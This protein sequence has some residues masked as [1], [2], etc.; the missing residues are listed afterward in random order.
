MAG[1]SIGLYKYMRI[2]E[3]LQKQEQLLESSSIISREDNSSKEETDANKMFLC[4][5]EFDRMGLE[6]VERF[7]KFRDIPKD[8]R[9]WMG[10]RQM[11]LVYSICY[12]EAENDVF[13]QNGNFF[14]NIESGAVQSDRLFIGLTILQ[15]G[16]SVKKDCQNV[17]EFFQICRENI[18]KLVKNSGRDLK[19]TVMGTLGSFG[20]TILWLANQYQDVLHLVT[21]I[22]NRNIGSINCEEKS[23]F[24]SA[25]T[26]FARNHKYGNNWDE[27]IRQIQ[28]SAI[29]SITL[30]VGLSDKICKNFINLLERL[31]NDK[32]MHCTGEH[33]VI[34]RIKSSNAFTLFSKNN[35]LHYRSE[36]YRNNLLQTNVNLCEDKEIKNNDSANNQGG[37]EKNHSDIKNRNQKGESILQI[38]MKALPELNSVADNYKELRREFKESFQSTTGMIDTLDMLFSDYLS[39]IS[40]ATN[41]MWADTLSHQFLCVL[42]CIKEICSS[43]DENSL[44]NSKRMGSINELLSDFARQVSYI[45]ESN[46]LVLATPVCQFQYL[47]QNNLTL[48]AYLGIMK[49]VLGFVYDSQEVSRQ[50]EIVPLMVAEIVPIIE[51]SMHIG[52]KLTE[53]GSKVITV[54]MPMASLYDAICYYPYLYHEIFH[55]VVPKD[56]YVRNRLTGSMISMEILFNITLVIICEGLQ[57]NHHTEKARLLYRVILEC[58]MPFIYKF[59]LRNYDKYINDS[60]ID[61][62]PDNLEYS[63]IDSQE[64]STISREYEREL[65]KRWIESLQDSEYPELKNNFVYMYFQYLYEN[66]SAFQ[67]CI[68]KWYEKNKNEKQADNIKS[69]VVRFIENLDGMIR[70][71]EPK[72]AGEKFQELIGML[73]DSV[74]NDAYLFAEALREL[75][76]DLAMVSLCHLEY[77]EYLLLFTKI[78]RDLIIG[79]KQEIQDILRVGIIAEYYYAASLDEE[80]LNDRID[81]QKD[82]YIQMYCGLFYSNTKHKN[83]IDY[84]YELADE[85]EKWFE[86]W[87]QCCKS[88]MLRYSIYAALFRS[89]CG[90][91]LVTKESILINGMKEE[92]HSYWKKYAEYLLEFGYYLL[93]KSKHQTE[94]QQKERRA[95]MDKQIFNLNIKLIHDFQIQ[96]E[97]QELN[98]RREDKRKKDAAKV[99]HNN[100]KLDS[101]N[102]NFKK[103]QARLKDIGVR[104]E[105]YADRAGQAADIITVIADQLNLANDRILGR[106]EHP[107]WYRG[108]EMVEYK[109]I[110]NIM[111]KYKDKKMEKKNHDEFFI[112]AYLR[113]EY[114]EFKFRTDGSVEAID[115]GAY[116]DADYIALMQ[117]YS[118]PTNFLDWT[119]DAMSALYFALEGF[120]DEKVPVKKGD[121][122]LYLFSPELY[123][124]ARNKMLLQNRKKRDNKTEIEKMILENTCTEVIPNISVSYHKDSYFMFLLGN[125]KYQTGGNYTEAKGKWKYYMPMAVY[126]S[127]L[128]NRI[129]AQSGN[130]LAYNIYTGPDNKNEF[131]H[132]DL[133]YIQKEYLKEY[134]KNEDT[135]PFLYKVIIKEAYRKEIAKWVKTFGMAKEKCYPELANIGERIMR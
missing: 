83:G 130:F 28:G 58:F 33:D 29:L 7:T 3:N 59:V 86:Y 82:K 112:D 25:Y 67:D 111:R 134:Q 49:N 93:G 1:Y 97:F 12:D 101:F 45:A 78:K 92:S 98:K 31:D 77:S 135:C 110:P 90:E 118:T 73:S 103:K 50:D 30:K 91:A 39:K 89:L 37:D 34:F 22:K 99:Y 43:W 16:F 128:N 24:L 75:A 46:N 47:G 132:V 62:Q 32:L 63:A 131:N 96:P 52:N 123:N 76:P 70:C 15:F 35:I 94:E 74:L 114:E 54:N 81:M 95:L 42:E 102:C 65:F 133:E 122:A 38:E 4:F 64:S 124:Y 19:C 105:Y 119:E 13:Y 6:R 116:T 115:Y 44:D 88:Y 55:Y 66:I 125:N 80:M 109:L 8:G 40:N 106:G 107:I 18:L 120:L 129:R 68:Q 69:G 127:R 11:H 84:L 20:L 10:D 9:A 72:S 56:R 60:I 26:I 14:E 71:S 2:G 17:S 79:R 48:Y 126:V 53:K 61:L 117:H 100:L 51:S 121:A 41:E 57:E 21:E 36:F 5:G 87:R 113:Q 23:I 85:A 108:H 104:W 27:K